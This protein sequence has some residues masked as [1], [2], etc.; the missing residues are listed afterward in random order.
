MKRGFTLLELLVVIAIIGIISAV[1]CYYL[2]NAFS[3]IKLQAMAQEIASDL[4]LCGQ[5][6][7]SEKTDVLI[8][9]N[10]NNYQF[11]SK[12]KMLPKPLTILNPQQVIFSQT[13]NPHPGYFGTIVLTDGQ[14]TKKIVISP[15]G[16]IR[17][18]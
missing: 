1:G 15:V 12:N 11:L 16:R 9:F 18:E 4:R 17:I 7:L 10:T 6:A 5:K 13:G 2:S 8:I 3:S 14:N